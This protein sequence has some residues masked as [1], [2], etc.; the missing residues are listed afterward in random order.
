MDINFKTK[1]FFFDRKAVIDY[2]GKD[3]A[4][5]LKA[6]KRAGSF[7]R[8]RARS[9]LG[10]KTK[11]V[12]RPF[13]PPSIHSGDKTI[14]LKNI[15]YAYDFKSSSMVIGSVKLHSKNTGGIPVP[16]LLEK[17][18]TVIRN[19]KPWNYRPHPWMARALIAEVQ[20]GTIPRQFSMKLR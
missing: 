9:I 15:Q 10:N 4:R 3:G 11:G 16:Q 13:S 2:F 7:I 5:T 17:G 20:A 19:G 12:S 8:T 18:G 1:D 6:L 14:S